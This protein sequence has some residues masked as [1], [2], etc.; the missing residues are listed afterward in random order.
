MCRNASDV[1]NDAA[2]SVKVTRIGNHVTFSS[3]RSSSN[4]LSNDLCD[5]PLRDARSHKVDIGSSAQVEQQLITLPDL[6]E[7][8][9]G[10][11][12]PPWEYRLVVSLSLYL[13]WLH[14]ANGGN[15]H[16]RPPACLP[17]SLPDV[18][19][20]PGSQIPKW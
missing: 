16:R 9:T 18:D 20:H 5:I 19:A 1:D 13:K 10:Y 8:P 12:C 11:L 2:Y 7:E 3:S 15:S 6:N 4:R 17:A 14:R